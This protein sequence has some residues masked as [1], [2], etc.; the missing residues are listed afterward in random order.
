MILV[1]NFIYLISTFSIFILAFFVFLNGRKEK[2][3]LLFSASLLAAGGWLISL[4]LFYNIESP[5]LVLWVGRF[6]FAIILPMLYFLFKFVLIF[7]KEIIV[8]P[9]RFN[10]IISCWFF[11]ATVLTFITPWVDKEEIITASGQRETIYGPLLFLYALNFLIFSCIIIFLLFYKMKKFK[12]GIV[13]IQIKYVLVG[14]FA[15]L[16]LGF[17]VTIVLSSVGLF[18]ASNYAPLATVIFSI[19]V[20][21]AIFKHHLF[22]IKVIAT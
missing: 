10:L 18:E 8:I 19:F 1:K 20:T 21:M 13:I 11:I 16:A 12:E 22:S 4:F 7:P 17:I 5:E 15:A 2:I 3:N 6:N 9:K 14:L